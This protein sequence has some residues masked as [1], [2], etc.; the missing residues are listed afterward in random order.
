VSDPREN[1]RIRLEIDIPAGLAPAV[2]LPVQAK[3]R[4]PRRLLGPRLDDPNVSSVDPDG[5]T[6]K[7]VRPRPGVSATGCIC[8]KVVFKVPVSNVNGMVY[9]EGVSNPC[10]EPC[11]GAVPGQDDGT[12]MTWTWDDAQTPPAAGSALPCADHMPTPP[13]P[14]NTFVF[15]YTGPDG[16]LTA[17]YVQFQGQTGNQGFCGSGSGSGGLFGTAIHVLPATL[18]AVITGGLACDGTY[19]LTHSGASSSSGQSWGY[20]GPLGSCPAVHGPGSNLLVTHHGGINRWSLTTPG[21]T[22]HPATASLSPLRLVFANQNLRAC[23]GSSSATITI[24]S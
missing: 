2:Q 22:A 1:I 14:T 19:A 7:L 4:G 6:P 15:W 17:D 24:V 10:E 5:T 9:P 18:H 11:D 21:G 8:A 16:V 13:Y 12:H 23:G 20:A 3:A